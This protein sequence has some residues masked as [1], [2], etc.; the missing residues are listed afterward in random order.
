M[1]TLILKI[2]LSSCLL[3]GFYYLFLERERIFKFN[4]AFLVSTLV[5]AYAIPFIPFNYPFVQKGQSNLIIG[6]PLQNFQQINI[7]QTSTL[8]W[9]KIF[10]ILYLAISILFFIKF[11]YAIIKIKLLKGEKIKYKDQNIFIINQYYAPFSFLNTIYFSRK[12]LV[13]YQID[14]RIFLHEKCHIV[15]KHSADILFIEFLKV[16]SWFNPA[17]FFF[18]KA[19][20]T[21]HEFLADEYVLQN[22]YD[23]SNYQHLILNEI[24]ISQ[25]F[26]LTHQFD[27]NNTKKRFIMMTSKNSRFT[28][29]KK[30]TLLPMLAIL[31]VLFTKKVDAQTATSVVEDSILPQNEKQAIAIRTD[32]TNSTPEAKEYIAMTD[33]ITVDHQ[34]K[35]DTIKKKQS[36]DQAVPATPPPPPPPPPSKFEQVPAEFPGGA[37]ALR[38]LVSKSFDISIFKGNESLIKTTVY[39]SIDLKG[40]ISN[41]FAEGDNKIFNEEA[42]RALTIANE[43]KAWKPATEG[44]N[45]VKTAYKLPLTMQFEGPAA[46]K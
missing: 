21:N 22:N 27:F 8:N 38:S 10:I 16:F 9:S 7:A 25:S 13:N 29:V 44:G 19:M 39:L 18:K 20:I 42:I 2:I 33:Q 32:E 35:K 14:E 5:F 37:N 30:L 40:K 3:I 26:K 43:G 24:K 28:W 41:I 45:P 34:L 36:P 12:Y 6:D 23:V 31:F 1:E 46:K 15:E 11:I 4:R 17:L